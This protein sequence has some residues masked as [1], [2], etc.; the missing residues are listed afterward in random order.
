[1]RL[2]GL[3]DGHIDR[4]D[5]P[6]W[7]ILPFD[8]QFSESS[9]PVL[10]VLN[11][12]NLPTVYSRPPRL[13][14]LV[15]SG[16]EGEIVADFTEAVDVTFAT[17]A[18]GF[19]ELTG[20]MPM[21]LYSA[22]SFYHRRDPLHIEV[23]DGRQIIYEGRIEDIRI[24]PGGLFFQAF[25]YYRALSDLLM[26]AM[27]SDTHLVDWFELNEDD[28]ADAS[29]A[30]FT[31][32]KTN[33]LYIAPNKDEEFN[34]GSP[35]VFGYRVPTLSTTQIESMLFNYYM[36]MS[37]PWTIEIHRCTSEWVSQGVIW[38]LVGNGSV[39]SGTDHF[40][41]FTPCDGLLFMLYYNGS[42]TVFSGDTGDAFARIA[43]VKI[44]SVPTSTLTAIDVVK[45]VIDHVNAIN[46]SQL[47]ADYSELQ[48][49]GVDIDDA[50]YHDAR[51]ADILSEVAAIGDNQEPPQQYL[52]QVWDGRRVHFR[53]PASIA[54]SWYVDV[55]NIMVERS[56][57]DQYN[58]VY[59]TYN[60][61]G[62]GN[63]RTGVASKS[64]FGVVRMAT[65]DAKTTS[66]S[67]A[68]RVRDTHLADVSRDRPR[69]TM[70]TEGLYD[71]YGIE[72]PLYEARAGDTMTLRNL[73]PDL[74]ELENLRTF[75][76]G[77]TRYDAAQNILEPEPDDP[78]PSLA[79]IV[80]RQGA[81]V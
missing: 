14:L 51:P 73:P 43:N 10:D 15:R 11:S 34:D 35:A 67:L 45:H 26:S 77:G 50:L 68:N 3:V 44:R 80:A 9:T 71:A 60:D 39:Q 6:A 28:L 25:G 41:T 42:N 22:F 37:S 46:P 16:P 32:D 53:P 27:Y 23:T 65:V 78:V 81:N 62:R 74:G 49:P 7:S 64:A 5:R 36:N 20:M 72:Y 48:D 30:R 70:M 12:A 75:R 52:V 21:N 2:F 61:R 66:E 59:A 38:S 47:L 63:T 13:S 76:I 1:M 40:E 29:P 56:L 58:A 8:I 19:A 33:R 79:V 57:G 24:E 17:G 54:R 4:H 18:H 31:L 69:A 55:V